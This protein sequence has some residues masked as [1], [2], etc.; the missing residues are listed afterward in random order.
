MKY[1]EGN[2]MITYERLVIRLFQESDAVNVATFV[3]TIIFIKIHFIYL[4]HIQWMM[5]NLGLKT[6]LKILIMKFLMNLQ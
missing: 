5:L 6:I 1:D 4:I 2:K 3:I